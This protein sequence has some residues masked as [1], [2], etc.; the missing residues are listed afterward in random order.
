MKLS[1]LLALALALLM[2]L[3]L[4]ACGGSESKELIMATNAQFPPYEY[5]EGEEIV[6]FEGTRYGVYRTYRGRDDTIELYLERKA[7]V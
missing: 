2:V 6:E 4:A 7:G 1:K 5:Y 3:G